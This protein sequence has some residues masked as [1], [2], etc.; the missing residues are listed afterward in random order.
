MLYQRYHWEGL[1]AAD[2]TVIARMMLIAA[3]IYINNR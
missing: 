2:D 1:V 3:V